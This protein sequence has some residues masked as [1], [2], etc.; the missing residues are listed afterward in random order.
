MS[1]QGL[2]LN[3]NDLTDSLLPENVVG[4]INTR[5]DHRSTLADKAIN[6]TK[7]RRWGFSNR[8]KLKSINFL[9]SYR[10]PLNRGGLTLSDL[11]KASNLIIAMVLKEK[12]HV[13][14][15]MSCNFF[16]REVFC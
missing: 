16:M 6:A 7:R 14:P 9:I 13:D 11:R 2:K 1:L 5:L 12:F 8:K 3:S 10:S 15:S 4:S